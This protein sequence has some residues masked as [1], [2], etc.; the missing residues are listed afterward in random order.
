MLMIMRVLD[1]LSEFDQGP[2]VFVT[3]AELESALVDHVEDQVVG[4]RNLLHIERCNRERHLLLRGP[5]WSCS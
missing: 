3:F 4:V 5:L 2:S 1:L